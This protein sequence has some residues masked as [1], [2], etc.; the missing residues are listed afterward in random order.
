MIYHT[1]YSRQYIADFAEI[2]RSAKN[3]M[4]K[5]YAVN[6]ISNCLGMNKQLQIFWTLRM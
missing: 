2:I 1:N 6:C 4:G 3:V 5:R